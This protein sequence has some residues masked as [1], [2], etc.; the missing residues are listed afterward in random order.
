MDASNRSDAFVARDGVEHF[1]TFLKFCG[2]PF[3]KGVLMGS[4]PC[5]SG[6]PLVR[7]ISIISWRISDLMRL[8]KAMFARTYH[9]ITNRTAPTVRAVDVATETRSGCGVP[10]PTSCH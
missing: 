5:S 8:T 2:L 7:C 1:F 6:D 3:G 4:C 9:T 10:F